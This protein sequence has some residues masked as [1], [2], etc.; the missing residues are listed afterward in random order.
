MLLFF[1]HRKTLLVQQHLKYL[2]KL[3]FTAIYNS[4][5]YQSSSR[6]PTSISNVSEEKLSHGRFRTRLFNS[7]LCFLTKGNILILSL[8][9]QDWGKKQIRDHLAAR[10]VFNNSQLCSQAPSPQRGPHHAART[11]PARYSVCVQSSPYHPWA[12]SLIFLCSV[13]L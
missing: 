10:A 1:T 5:P 9:P 12:C 11:P 6:V 4:S 2:F 3:Q 7:S 8:L 13:F